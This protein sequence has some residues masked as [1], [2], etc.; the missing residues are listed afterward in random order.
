[1]LCNE[2]TVTAFIYILQFPLQT[3]QCINSVY[4]SKELSKLWDKLQ[5]SIQF[6]KRY[7]QLWV[8]QITAADL[9][10]QY[11]IPHSTAAREFQAF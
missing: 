4:A 9:A 11:M 8:L 7:I 6:L 3:R 2:K 5:N 10:Y 1:M